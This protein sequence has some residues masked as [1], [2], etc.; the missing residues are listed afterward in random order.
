MCLRIYEWHAS[1]PPVPWHC[2]DVMHQPSFPAGCWWEGGKVLLALGHGSRG[3]WSHTEVAW[4]E[5]G[6]RLPRGRWGPRAL[7]VSQLQPGRSRQSARVF[8]GFCFATHKGKLWQGDSVLYLKVKHVFFN[9]I[10]FVIY[11]I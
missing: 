3:T 2:Q 1:I 5:D 9:S 6:V 11:S 10:Q 7:P 8:L 4:G